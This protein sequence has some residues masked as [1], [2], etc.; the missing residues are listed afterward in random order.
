MYNAF[1]L[2]LLGFDFYLFDICLYVVLKQGVVTL[3]KKGRFI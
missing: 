3:H 2:Y 1:Y